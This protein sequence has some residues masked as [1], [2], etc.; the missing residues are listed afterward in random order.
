MRPAAVPFR[1]NTGNPRLGKRLGQGPSVRLTPDCKEALLRSAAHVLR[2]SG[3]ADLVFVGRSPE[4]LFDL[5]CG[6]LADTSWRDR[7]Q[8]LQLSLRRRTPGQL[9][10]ELPG[11]LGQLWLYF[12]SLGLTPPQLLER[13][14]PVA[15]VDMVHS[16]RTFG[17]LL[18]V[19]RRWCE[20]PGAWP[21]VLDRLRWVCI[22]ERGHPD[23]EPWEP[24]HSPWTRAFRAD[25]V[26]RVFIDWRSWRYFAE[27]QPKSTAAHTPERWGSAEARQPSQD[28][29][30]I[31]AAR[32]ARSLFYLGRCS[33]RRIADALERPPAPERWLEGVIREIR[34][35]A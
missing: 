28:E 14:R 13:P 15:V 17:N 25:R 30:R 1:W 32:L 11:A 8:L 34:V 4:N 27:D 12:S 26:R 33:R 20:Q 31:R 35:S 18:K 6:L 29:D 5:L 16:G 9:R 7:V 10:R 24:S 19:L 23:W 22:V 2:A 21:D 3:G